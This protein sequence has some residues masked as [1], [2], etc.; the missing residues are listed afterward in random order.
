[1][2]HLW[3]GKPFVKHICEGVRAYLPLVAGNQLIRQTH[4]IRE[5]Q[6]ERHII[7]SPMQ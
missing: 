5:I 4:G 7:V 3:Q 2:S 6:S 1:M